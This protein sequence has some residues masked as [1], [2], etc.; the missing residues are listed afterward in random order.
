MSDHKPAWVTLIMTL[1]LGACQGNDVQ[2]PAKSPDKSGD[3]GNTQSAGR[4]VDA[5]T[6]V[7]P[8]GP[9]KSPRLPAEPAPVSV[10]SFLEKQGRKSLTVNFTAKGVATRVIYGRFRDNFGPDTRGVVVLNILY[11]E[12]R[13][14][15]E[16]GAFGIVIAPA[17]ALGKPELLEV[18]EADFLVPARGSPDA[19]ECWKPQPGEN[20]I[21]IGREDASGILYFRGGWRWAFCGD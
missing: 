5:S 11:H 19:L 14:V 4:H 20:G 10:D 2:Q 21:F 17:G 6:P 12:K 3:K 15:I 13:T 9:T 16:K 18:G 8:P 1:A 7:A